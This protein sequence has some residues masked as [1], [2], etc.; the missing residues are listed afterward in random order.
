LLSK[1]LVSQKKR[2]QTSSE[3]GI[4]CQRNWHWAAT[5][6]LSGR[7]LVQPFKKLS[8]AAGQCAGRGCALIK[9]LANMSRNKI[10]QSDLEMHIFV[11]VM[12]R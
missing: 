3:M 12:L 8:S 11:S 1:H 10:T 6:H 7:S 4:G 5:S 9:Q 2:T